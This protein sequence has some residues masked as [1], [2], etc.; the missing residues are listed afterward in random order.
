MNEL[1]T[2]YQCDFTVDDIDYVGGKITAKV[3]S[4]G[5]HN[6]VEA[7][8]EPDMCGNAKHKVDY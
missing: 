3:D 1:N 8:V 2:R 5:Y 6:G 7:P 4:L